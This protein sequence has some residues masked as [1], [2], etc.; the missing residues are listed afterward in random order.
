MTYTHL[1]FQ[2]KTKLC[3]DSPRISEDGQRVPRILIVDDDSFNV[4]A[5]KSL[6]QEIGRFEIDIASNG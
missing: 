4:F 3:L 1:E 6:I 5:L 2:T